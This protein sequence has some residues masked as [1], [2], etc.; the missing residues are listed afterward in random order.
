MGSIDI[1]DS[2]ISGV[3]GFLFL[4]FGMFFDWRMNPPLQYGLLVGFYD[5]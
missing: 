4:D 1:M 3:G 5:Y 2:M